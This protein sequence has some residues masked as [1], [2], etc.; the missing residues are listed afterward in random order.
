M[1]RTKS[2]RAGTS[3][4]SRRGALPKPVAPR[5]A[6]APLYHQVRTALLARITSGQWAPG[7]TLPNEFELAA[8]LGVSQGTMRRALD[9]LVQDRLLVRL[10]GSGTVVREATAADML[11]RFF[12]IFDDDG[13]Q[14]APD[15]RDARII[16]RRA[17]AAE[18]RRLDLDDREPRAEVLQITRIRTRSGAPFISEKLLLPAT[19]FSGLE[20]RS[21]LPNTLYDLFQRQFGITVARAEETVTPVAAGVRDAAQLG[22]T[23]GTPLLKIDR[24]TFSVDGRIIEWRIS[25][26]HL[27]HAHY[28]ARVG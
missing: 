21:P 26:C 17:F 13:R 28:R 12:R 5:G 9:T 1:P 2:A 3:S 11:F 15:S 19:L 23:V 20:R 16:R 4:A 24:T 7:L 14:I 8:E 18:R 6:R 10:Q 27:R 22:I 25:L